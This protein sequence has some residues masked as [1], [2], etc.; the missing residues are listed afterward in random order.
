MPVT[1]EAVGGI[2]LVTVGR[3]A[4][5]MRRMVVQ[6]DDRRA[7]AIVAF[8]VVERRGHEPR[9]AR[10]GHHNEPRDGARAPQGVQHSI[11]SLFGT[12]HAVNVE[13]RCGSTV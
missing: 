11:V 9:D 13:A 7:I 8:A 5:P 2:G 4:N 10:Q 12:G 3:S 6:R 1:D